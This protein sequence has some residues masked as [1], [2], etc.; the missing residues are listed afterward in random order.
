MR[1]K[2]KRKK[3][4]R[5]QRQKKKRGRE[6]R[7]LDRESR[8]TVLSVSRFAVRNKGPHHIKLRLLVLLHAAKQMKNHFV[9]GWEGN[10]CVLYTIHISPFSHHTYL[11][12]NPK[13]GQQQFSIPVAYGNTLQPFFHHKD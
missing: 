2:Q 8:H 11:I 5:R 1:K 10:H 3:K 7:K 12:R 9:Q 6:A 4:K 13:T